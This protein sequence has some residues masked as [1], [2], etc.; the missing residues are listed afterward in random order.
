M[1]DFLENFSHNWSGKVQFFTFITTR[2]CTWGKR[3]KS[4]KNA[5]SK[6]YFNKEDLNWVNKKRFPTDLKSI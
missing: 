1:Q 2:N 4:N 5:I 6:V 3:G